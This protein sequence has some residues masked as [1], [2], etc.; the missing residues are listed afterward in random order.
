MKFMVFIQVMAFLFICLA[1]LHPFIPQTIT[2]YYS[3]DPTFTLKEATVVENAIKHFEKSIR[4]VSLINAEGLPK[5]KKTNNL[6]IL[7]IHPVDTI[8]ESTVGLYKP[9]LH[10]IL[11]SRNSID[12]DKK[13]L[14]RTVRPL[15]DDFRFKV[16]LHEIA[17][18]LGMGGHPHPMKNSRTS[19]LAANIS[20]KS[21]KYL[22][23]ND[24]IFLRRLI[25][26]K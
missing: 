7:D 9:D 12:V 13:T 23:K 17:H 14:E 19:H 22:Y 15:S 2:Q 10:S 24:V 6:M 8:D 3:L 18:A 21:F 26:Y 16:T 20:R 25:C 4:C 11:I 5:H 1:P